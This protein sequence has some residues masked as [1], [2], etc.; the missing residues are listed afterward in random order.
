MK[1]LKGFPVTL[2]FILAECP[3]A[4]NLNPRIVIKARKRQMLRTKK[5]RQEL[6]TGERDEWATW[7]GQCGKVTV[8]GIQT[9]LRIVI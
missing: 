5:A 6:V 8:K 1:A 7:G 2:P 4:G 3:L 9:H